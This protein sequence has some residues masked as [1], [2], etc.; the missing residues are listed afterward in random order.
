VS[1]RTVEVASIAAIAVAVLVGGNALLVQ[2]AQFHGLAI[3][4]L[5][6][7][8]LLVLYAFRQN[9]RAGGPLARIHATRDAAFLAAI[10]G[11]IAFVALPARWSLGATIV[12]TEIGFAVELLARLAPASP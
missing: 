5:G 1:A 4:V 6:V 3:S 11:A 10:A 9:F 2:I 8:A 7:L 12:A